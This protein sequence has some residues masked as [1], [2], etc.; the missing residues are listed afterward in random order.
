M[1]C[2]ATFFEITEVNVDICMKLFYRILIGFRL[3]YP[4]FFFASF[5]FVSSEECVALGQRRPRLLVAHYFGSL[6]RQTVKHTVLLSDCFRNGLPTAVP[7][8]FHWI[9]FGSSFFL[10]VGVHTTRSLFRELN[11]ESI[12]LIQQERKLK[13]SFL[14]S[15]L[16]FSPNITL[17]KTANHKIILRISQK[18][19]D[20]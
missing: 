3:N 12:I 13:A 19:F 9:N 6:N 18:S 14:I 2:K 10:S 17:K 20:P 16:K 15:S 5:V 7:T 1:N 11:L 8:P 4:S